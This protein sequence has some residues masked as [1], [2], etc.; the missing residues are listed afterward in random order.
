MAAGVRVF[1]PEHRLRQPA[2]FAAVIADSRRLGGRHFDLR[3]R[4]NGGTWARLGLIV[5]KRLARRAVLRNT[6]KRLARE[7]FR[8]ALPS[9]PA[10]DLVLRLTRPPVPK[11]G[12]ISRPLRLA[13]RL[14]LD[15]LLASVPR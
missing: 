11:G 9:L 7:S 10:V 8:Q 4:G 5:P 12:E 1:R 15:E 6:L 3:F 13:W 14:E 2:E